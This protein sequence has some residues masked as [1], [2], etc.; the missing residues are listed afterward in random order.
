MKLPFCRR[1]RID[2]AN[3]SK[4]CHF[5]AAW[6]TE[7]KF[8]NLLQSQLVAATA[9][10]KLCRK[11]IDIKKMGVFAL[12]L[13]AKSRKHKNTVATLVSASPIKTHFACIIKFQ[14]LYIWDEF[15]VFGN[16]EWQNSLYSH[17]RE[18]TTHR[19]NL[20]V[21]ISTAQCFSQ[22]FIYAVNLIS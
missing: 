10:C 20:N 5:Q 14:F 13:H 22:I 9:Y 12:D 16:V 15:F 11:I 21:L 19:K 18:M 6:L 8:K 7:S 2:I 3:M 4:E 1:D 17:S